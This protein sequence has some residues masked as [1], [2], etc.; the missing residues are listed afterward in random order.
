[1][2][3]L[4][5][6]HIKSQDEEG[7]MVLEA[8][9][10]MPL[11]VAVVIA[12]ASFLSVAIADM[13]LYAGLS[14]TTKQ[15][16]AHMYP[17]Q[18][19]TEHALESERGRKIVEWVERIRGAKQRVDSLAVE[20]DQ[21]AYMIP[22]SFVD[23]IHA[24]QQYSEQ[25]DQMAEEQKLRMLAWILEPIVA[26]NTDSNVW[27]KGRARI[28]HVDFPNLVTR[29]HPYFGIE[30]EYTIKLPIPFVHRTVTVR[31]KA[32]ERIWIGK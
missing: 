26:A 10:I 22:K 24:Y 13:A 25:A 31:H 29:E 1:L 11:F 7:S 4:Q 27:Q 17:V 5:T 18:E 19:I 16:A 9:L 3:F 30:A 21:H 20:A 32:Y 12:I 15:V 6:M 8:S 2:P 23:L 28:V 14:E